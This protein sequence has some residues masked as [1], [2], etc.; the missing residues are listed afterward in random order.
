MERKDVLERAKELGIELRHKTEK[1]V[2]IIKKIEDLT[3]EKIILNANTTA[4]KEDKKSDT[5]RAIIHSNDKDNDYVDAYV[6]VNGDNATFPLGE[7]IDFPKKF[8]PCIQ[9][10]VTKEKIA[11]LDAK[12]AVTGEYK[13]RIRKNYILER[14]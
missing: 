5:I 9:D 1:T 12:G 3:G 14:I 10:A 4:P 8:L 7:E 6:G 11:I 13:T 2:D